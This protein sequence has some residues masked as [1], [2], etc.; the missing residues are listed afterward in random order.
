MLSFGFG[1]IKEKVKLDHIVSC[2]EIDVTSVKNLGGAIYG[3]MIGIDGSI[4]YNIGH[5]KVVCIKVRD[6]NDYIIPTKNPRK[7]CELLRCF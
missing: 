7:L 3:R 2:E 4:I 5:K 6:S 1:L